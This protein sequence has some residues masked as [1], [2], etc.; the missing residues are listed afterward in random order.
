MLVTSQLSESLE[1]YLETILELE[2][3]NKVARA[4]D[5]ADKLNLQRGSVTGALKSLSSAGLINYEPY[6]F[7][8]LTPKGKKYA[9]DIA[10]RHQAIKDFLL[11]V[12]QI[13]EATAEETACRMEHVIDS[14]TID[15]LVCFIEY[16]FNCP[17]AGEQWIQS[18]KNYCASG[19]LDKDKCERC[20][21]K[22]Q[23]AISG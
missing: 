22:L 18:F 6:S 5:I 12:L 1:N 14:S 20:I 2:K 16:V 7:I 23:A 13:E 9:T 8:T 4:K 10:F 3:A 17:R 21:D 19:E 11:K 15:R